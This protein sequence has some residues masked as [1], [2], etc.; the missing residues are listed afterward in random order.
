MSPQCARVMIKRISGS[1]A[2][3]G[4]QQLDTAAVCKQCDHPPAGSPESL[5]RHSIPDVPMVG[6]DTHYMHAGLVALIVISSC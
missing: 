6:R 4:K 5:E 2:L 1:A 3:L